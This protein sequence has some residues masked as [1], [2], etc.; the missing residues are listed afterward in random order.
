M[1][2]IIGMV[3]GGL[4]ILAIAIAV[5]VLAVKIA[6]ILLPIAFLIAVICFFFF[7]CDSNNECKVYK[8]TDRGPQVEYVERLTNIF[9]KKMRFLCNA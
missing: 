3:A 7:R 2:E 8:S 4:V 9:T 1:F 5:L 6:L